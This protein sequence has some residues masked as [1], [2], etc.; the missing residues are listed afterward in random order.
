MPPGFGPVA[1]GHRQA[2]SDSTKKR[3][4]NGGIGRERPIKT[5]ARKRA[6]P[7]DREARR[8][9]PKWK[10]SG[11]PQEKWRGGDRARRQF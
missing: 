8:Q 9:H 3:K 11:K 4:N 10:K 7:L 1:R 2:P 5:F 6:N